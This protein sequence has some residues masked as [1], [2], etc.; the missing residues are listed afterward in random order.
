MPVA[1]AKVPPA[2]VVA[3]VA[4]AAVDA[5]VPRPQGVPVH[6]ANR[7]TRVALTS[8]AHATLPNATSTDAATSAVVDA[9][10]PGYLTILSD[11]PLVIMEDGKQ[12]GIAPM[13]HHTLSAGTHRLEVRTVDG[14][15]LDTL[16]VT[17]EPGA[18]SMMNLRTTPAE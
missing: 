4:H 11:M 12:V 6:V 14:A 16:P 9:H 2:P 7:D 18:L 10:T 1:T 17:V 13:H 8:Q 3:P 15:V 5:G